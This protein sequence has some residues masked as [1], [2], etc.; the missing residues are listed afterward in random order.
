MTYQELLNDSFRGENMVLMDYEP[1]VVMAKIA[2]AAVGL[3]KARKPGI[4][5]EIFSEKDVASIMI[6]ETNIRK[7]PVPR[8]SMGFACTW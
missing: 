2:P 7:W 1:T 8:P 6:S 4:I 5:A 3:A